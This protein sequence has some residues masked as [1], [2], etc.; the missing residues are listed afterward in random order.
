MDT[1]GAVILAAGESSRLGEPK[2]LL[3]YRGCSLIRRAINAAIE[4]GCAPIMVILG[5]DVASVSEEI[6]QDGTVIVENPDW[7]SGIGTSVRTGVQ[8]LLTVAPKTKA[9]VLLVCDQPF[10]N[11]EV[12]RKLIEHWRTEGK[13]IVASAYS[14]TLGVPALLDSSC[15]AELLQ[16]GDSHGAKSIILRLPS[17]V[18]PFDFA[19]GSI[20]IDNRHDYEQICAKN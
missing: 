18:T 13:P 11:G 1:V 16:I 2:Q 14:G 15:F 17:R 12:V 7:R 10:V 6:P 8:Q 4:G 9:L 19:N 5:S 20:D 3:P